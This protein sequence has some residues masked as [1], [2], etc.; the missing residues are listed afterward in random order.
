MA[1]EKLESVLTTI[2]IM[3]GQTPLGK[4]PGAD[5]VRSGPLERRR[6]LVG[7][8]AA[9]RRSGARRGARRRPRGRAASRRR[10]P[11]PGPPAAPAGALTRR[12]A[13]P[14]ARDAGGLQHDL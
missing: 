5:A 9:A 12:A 1:G 4:K 3:A 14:R 6:R 10:L 7:A 2:E 11:L 8:A 13:D